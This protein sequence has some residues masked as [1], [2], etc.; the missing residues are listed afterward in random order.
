VRLPRFGTMGE[1]SGGGWGFCRG[2]DALGRE[3][4]E[5]VGKVASR[6][7][8]RDRRSEPRRRGRPLC[9]LLQLPVAT[10]T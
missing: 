1:R 4:D 8:A 7:W 2:D 6:S 10:K 3:R 9:L 5:A